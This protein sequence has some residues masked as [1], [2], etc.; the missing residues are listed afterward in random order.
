[1]FLPLKYSAISFSPQP[2]NADAVG[3][4]RSSSYADETALFL[5]KPCRLSLEEAR[6]HRELDVTKSSKAL[7]ELALQPW[8]LVKARELLI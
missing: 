2:T 4:F 3:Q 8:S 6:R 7:G 1:M 5:F